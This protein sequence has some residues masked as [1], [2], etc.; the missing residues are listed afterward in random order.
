MQFAQIFDMIQEILGE[1]LKSI[2]EYCIII[3]V[4]VYLSRSVDI[5][6]TV[7]TEMTGIYER[8]KSYEPLWENWYVGETTILGKYGDEVIYSKQVRVEY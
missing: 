6:F 8:T 7:V 2:V 5:Y 4:N 3:T 1:L